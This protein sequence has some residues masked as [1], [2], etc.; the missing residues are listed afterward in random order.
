MLCVRLYVDED[1]LGALNLYSN[2]VNGF[3]ASQQAEAVA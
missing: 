3:D 2:R 1:N